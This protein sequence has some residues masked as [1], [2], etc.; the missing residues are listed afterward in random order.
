MDCLY[1][2]DGGTFRDVTGLRSIR[3]VL[4][5]LPSAAA[6]VLI[7]HRHVHWRPHRN[8]LPHRVG[9]RILD[10]PEGRFSVPVWRRDVRRQAVRARAEDGAELRVWQQQQLP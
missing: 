6:D 9:L 5:L 7:L 10:Q 3:V 4:V 2:N 1:Q 8:R